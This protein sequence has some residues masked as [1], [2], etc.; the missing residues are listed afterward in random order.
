MKR[1][2]A[3]WEEVEGYGDGWRLSSSAEAYKRFSHLAEETKEHFYCVHLNSK[4]FV[5][6]LDL[7][8]IGS[9]N[10]AIVHPREVFKN[11]LLSSACAIL[12]IHNHPS[13]D[14]NPSREDIE[15]T[16]RLQQAGE[17]LGI[18]VLDHIVIGDGKYVSLSDRGLI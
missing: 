9:L 17:L 5:H 11:A 18:K 15:L 2:K 6:C 7:V 10:A 14:P 4:N 13:G 1:I 8:S 16:G 12:F 3:V